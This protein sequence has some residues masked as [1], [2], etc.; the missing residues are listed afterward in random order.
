MSYFASNHAWGGQR[1]T[2]SVARQL[3]FT[4]TA[5]VGLTHVGG[6]VH[7]ADPPR[8]VWVRLD[9]EL[10]APL[11]E[12]PLD[13]VQAVDEEILGVRSTGE[14]HVSARPKVTVVDDPDQ[15]AF[16]VTVTG[17][18]TSLTCTRILVRGIS[19][20]GAAG[21]C[22]WHHATQGTHPSSR[23]SPTREMTGW[24]IA[25]FLYSSLFAGTTGSSP[26]GECPGVLPEKRRA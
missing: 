4:L 16:T 26:A 3:V 14:A 20:A 1:R 21:G 18:M 15:A 23:A 13:E 6:F 8:Q 12:R 5:A 19:G 10:L 22:G 11:I 17:T 7:A 25:V 9:A 24:L 2:I